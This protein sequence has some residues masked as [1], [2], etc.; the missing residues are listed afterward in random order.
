MQVA[1]VGALPSRHSGVRVASAPGSG[2]P[3]PTVAPA[4]EFRATCSQPLM[5]TVRPQRYRDV[6]TQIKLSRPSSNITSL[7]QYARQGCAG[8]ADVRSPARRVTQEGLR[9][10]REFTSLSGPIWLRLFYL[11]RPS[12]ARISCRQLPRLI[13]SQRS[14][15]TVLSRQ[16]I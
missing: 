11:L 8:G 16:H 3:P 10:R 1:V 7:M 4:M 13:P 5:G 12:T 2:A 6:M 9:G 15:A 14:N